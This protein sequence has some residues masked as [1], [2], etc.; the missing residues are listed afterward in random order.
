ML[1]PDR[2]ILVDPL[3]FLSPRLHYPLSFVC[4]PSEQIHARRAAQNTHEPAESGTTVRVLLPHS[5]KWDLVF[6]RRWRCDHRLPPS[7]CD[8][9]L[10]ESLLS[11]SCSIHDPCH[12]PFSTL[13]RVKRGKR[14]GSVS[15]KFNRRISIS[16]HLQVGC[17]RRNNGKVLESRGEITRR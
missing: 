14:W 9:L 1:A 13:P 7:F 12:S 3:H 16:Q 6:H 5:K 8:R 17:E 15:R 10:H 4:V 11:T 2:L